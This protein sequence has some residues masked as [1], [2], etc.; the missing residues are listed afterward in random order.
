MLPV[1]KRAAILAKH[2]GKTVFVHMNSEGRTQR[3]FVTFE[4]SEEATKAPIV[5]V[6]PDGTWKYIG[7][8]NPTDPRD[9]SKQWDI[10]RKVGER[11]VGPNEAY[12]G[13]FLPF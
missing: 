7:W 9:I 11:N 2:H 10:P 12:G 1:H 4:F 3:D 5:R 6:E 13:K 8:L